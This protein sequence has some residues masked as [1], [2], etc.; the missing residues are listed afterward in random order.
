MSS[1]ETFS[2]KKARI[3]AGF[4]NQKRLAHDHASLAVMHGPGYWVSC[5][6]ERYNL[7][8]EARNNLR[9]LY[10]MKDEAGE[11]R[12]IGESLIRK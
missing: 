8:K 1:R 4:D 11:Y 7:G 12:I 2:K 10:W 9:A 3:L 6:E 5:F